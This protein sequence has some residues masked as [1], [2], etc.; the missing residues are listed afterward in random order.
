MK[1]KAKFMGIIFYRNFR[2]CLRVGPFCERDSALP[3]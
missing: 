1:Q 3:L 2:K